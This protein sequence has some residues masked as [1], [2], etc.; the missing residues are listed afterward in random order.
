M[1]APPFSL[2]I[3]TNTGKRFLYLLYKHFP[4]THRYSK[5]YNKCSVKLS[6][7][8]P[9]RKGVITCGRYQEPES[10]CNCYNLGSCP[11]DQQCIFKSIYLNLYEAGVTAI[12]NDNTTDKKTYNGLCKVEFKNLSANHKVSLRHKDKSKSTKL[13]SYIWTYER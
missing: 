10:S 11:L 2:N 3:E 7:W 5:I 9:N 6:Y 12:L 1:L 4:V 13:V 8:C